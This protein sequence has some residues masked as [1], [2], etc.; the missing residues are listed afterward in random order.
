MVAS[1]Y[2]SIVSG[3]P[4]SSE[5]QC[6]PVDSSL[7]GYSSDEIREAGASTC[8]LGIGTGNPLTF[9]HLQRGETVID[10]GCGSGIDCFLASG[11]VGAEGKVI[12]IDM[13]PEMI[14]YARRNAQRRIE[15]RTKSRFSNVTFRL[16]EIEYLPVS[17]STADC[18]ISNGVVNLSLE[19]QRVFHEMYRVLKKGGRIALSDVVIRPQRAIPDHLRTAQAHAA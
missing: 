17:D 2:A 12:G 6:V 8:D 9:A 16:G 4:V 15:D 1:R 10:L 7:Y 13:V 3:G 19:K 11:T 18:V 14:H 5:V